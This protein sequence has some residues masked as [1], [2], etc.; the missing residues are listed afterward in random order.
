MNG[1]HLSR[2]KG[3]RKAQAFVRFIMVMIIGGMFVTVEGLLWISPC[4][5]IPI[6]DKC[7]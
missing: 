4:K 5:V 1:K 3:V 7:G 6:M 2:V